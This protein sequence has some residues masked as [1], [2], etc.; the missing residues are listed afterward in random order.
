[1][2]YP[3]ASQTGRRVRGGEVSNCRTRSFLFTL[4]STRVSLLV[5]VGSY[6]LSETFEV[7]IHG[8]LDLF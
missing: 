5:R 1:M 7:E 6:L 3:G 4:L 8:T 2:I